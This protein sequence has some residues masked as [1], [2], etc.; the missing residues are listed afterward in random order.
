MIKSDNNDAAHHIEVVIH[1]TVF[2]IVLWLSTLS[3]HKL[4][5]SLSYTAF[6]RAYVITVRVTLCRA[7][8]T[9]ICV[10]VAYSIFFMVI[11]VTAMLCRFL[12]LWE[13]FMTYT[14]LF[15]TKA[16]PFFQDRSQDGGYRGYS[17]HLGKKLHLPLKL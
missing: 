4:N 11:H 1:G 14:G 7:V 3:A 6:Q 2:Y 9:M 15:R 13:Q 12:Y 16:M 17:P 5:A 8:I 10:F